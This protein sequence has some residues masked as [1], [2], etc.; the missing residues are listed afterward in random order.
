M[1]IAAAHIDSLIAANARDVLELLLYKH[2]WFKHKSF[3]PP[4]EDFCVKLFSR[5]PLFLESFCHFL[6]HKNTQLS[7]KLPR[8]IT[9]SPGLVLPADAFLAAVQSLY[10]SVILSHKKEPIK[11]P[12]DLAFARALF[13]ALLR[14][15][16]REAAEE[17]LFLHLD[18]GAAVLS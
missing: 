8:A 16:P 6:L 9:L 11:S 2:S 4:F 3:L 13:S 15:P 12:P 17:P 7:A 1:E 18:Q 10:K 5:A 14:A